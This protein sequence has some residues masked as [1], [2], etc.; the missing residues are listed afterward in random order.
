MNN[1]IVCDLNKAQ[2][3]HYGYTNQYGNKVPVLPLG[4]TVRGLLFE[5]DA[6][7]IKY[8]CT[9]LEFAKTEKLLDVWTPY[10]KFQFSA[11]HSLVYTGDKAKAMWHEWGKRIF[12]KGKSK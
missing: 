12:K 5:V 1:R 3:A 4:P 11:N 8:H 7:H 10:V 6:P 9:M 2:W